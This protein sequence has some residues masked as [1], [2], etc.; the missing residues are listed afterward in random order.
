MNRLESV[1]QVLFLA[2]KEKNSVVD[3]NK[4]WCGPIL[5]LLLW[6]LAVGPILSELELEQVGKCV[7]SVIPSRRR[8]EEGCF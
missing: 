3:E 4:G 2:D 1:S 7:A 6:L 8:E 5:M